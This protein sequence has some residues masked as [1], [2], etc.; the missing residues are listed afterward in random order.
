MADILRANQPFAYTDS[1]GTPRV[2]RPGDLFSAD[3]PCVKGRETLFEPVEVAAAR[4]A[5]STVE[6]ATSAPGERRSVSTTSR[7]RGKRDGSDTAS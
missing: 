4:K 6:Q 2:V 7:A 5:T 3:D 1:T